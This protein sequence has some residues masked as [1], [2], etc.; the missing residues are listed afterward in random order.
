MTLGWPIRKDLHLGAGEHDDP[1][2]ALGDD[3]RDRRLPEQDRDFAEEI[4]PAQQS[5]AARPVD[6]DLALRP[7]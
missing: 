2:A 4:A 7:R 3:V 6:A 1:N 5:H